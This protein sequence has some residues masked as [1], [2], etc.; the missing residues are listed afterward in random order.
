M[1]QS[2][3]V[4]VEGLNKTLRNLQRFGVEAE[5]LKDAFTEV[6]R[7]VVLNAQS[8][9]P[10]RSGAL[11]QSIRASRAKASATIRAGNNGGKYYASFVEYGTKRQSAQEFVTT[12]V[13]RNEQYTVSRIQYELDKLSKKHDLN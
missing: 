10:A 4:R 3:G 12:A 8:L 9:A 1:G 13:K 6:G 7:K 5:E 11:R 2:A